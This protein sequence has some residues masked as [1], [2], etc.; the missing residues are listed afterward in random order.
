LRGS[1]ATSDHGATGS[2]S[3]YDCEI[4]DRAR[5]PR[6]VRDTSL[7]QQRSNADRDT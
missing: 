3:S 4:I 7:P 2:E 1:A 5:A 6:I